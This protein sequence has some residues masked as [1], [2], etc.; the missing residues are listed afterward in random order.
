[1]EHL[2]Q[3]AA[4]MR[5]RRHPDSLQTVV[6]NAL[7]TLLLRRAVVHFTDPAMLVELLTSWEHC[8][9]RDDQ[10]DPPTTDDR[11]LVLH[12][13]LKSQSA[14]VVEQLL[15]LAIALPPGSTSLD[16]DDKRLQ[17]WQNAAELLPFRQRRAA[18][19]ILRGLAEQTG[20]GT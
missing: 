13:W 20:A 9:D 2:G 12:A 6:T 10:F 14:A 19:S 1:M 3:M 8:V 17:Q 5:R 4:V 7:A 11:L 15:T 18:R 16:W